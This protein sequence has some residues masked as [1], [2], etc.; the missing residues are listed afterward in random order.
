MLRAPV[1]TLVRG[2]AP[3]SARS[4][5]LTEAGA[6]TGDSAAVGGV[7]AGAGDVTDFTVASGIATRAEVSDAD[8]LTG[9]YAI[10]G[11]AALTA[12]VSQID[13]KTTNIPTL[14]TMSALARYTDINNWAR[15]EVL[16]TGQVRVLKRVA[17]TA[18]L[19]AAVYSTGTFALALDTWFTL[20]F[21]IDAVGRYY[22]WFYRQGSTSA[23]PLISYHDPDFAT[24]GAL[25]S[26]KPGFYDANPSVTVCTRSYDNFAAWVPTADAV[27]YPSKSCQLTTSGIS[28][29]DSTG[30]SSGPVSWQERDLPRLSS[31]GAE[32][33]PVQVFFKASR[34]DLSVAPDLGIDDASVQGFYK[35]CWLFVPNDIFNPLDIPGL[36][37][38]LRPEVLAANEASVDVWRDSSGNG[39]DAAQSTAGLQPLVVAGIDGY[40]AVR[41]D[42]AGDLLPVAALT[43]SDATRTIYVV[44]KAAATGGSVWGFGSSARL[45]PQDSSNWGYNVNAAATVTSLPGAPLTWQL[46]ALR[47]NSVSSAEGFVN[48]GGATSFDPDD[49]YQT[50]GATFTVGNRSGG[51]ANYNGDIQEV[52]VFNSALGTTNHNLLR[53]HLSRKYPTLGSFGT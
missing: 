41:F 4:E 49:S 44:A 37:L 31:S 46:V 21:H 6:I 38:W 25:A 36:E 20:S 40:R 5:F 27:I 7:W 17:G 48:G 26:G 35:P 28:H 39:N 19:L 13:V 51:G 30:V 42:G 18:T 3:F 12:Q 22:V 2:L 1:T 33:R 11:V 50:G 14:L 10:S 47:Y 43:A 15:A 16:D 24:G 45:N 8:N 29:E 9:R 53:G 23:T 34:S 52:L 32:Q